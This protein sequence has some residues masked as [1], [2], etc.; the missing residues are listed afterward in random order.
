M[1]EPEFTIKRTTW[2]ERRLFNT[3]RSPLPYL[4]HRWDV[5]TDG[6]NLK[7]WLGGFVRHSSAERYVAELLKL[8]A[9]EES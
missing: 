6:P 4:F 8:I 1:T 9:E 5:V 3:W 7:G 2:A